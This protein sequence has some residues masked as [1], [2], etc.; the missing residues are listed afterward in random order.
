MPVGQEISKRLMIARLMFNVRWAFRSYLRTPG[1]TITLLL[2]LALGVGATL[3]TFS[4]V[5]ALLLRSLGG[6]VHPHELVR[7]A[8]V[9]DRNELLRVTSMMRDSM[10]EMPAFAGVCAVNTPGGVVTI[11]DRVTFEGLLNVSGD[12]F[13]VLGTRPLLGRLLTAAS[14]AGVRMSWDRRLESTARRSPSSASRNRRFAV[15]R[16][17]FHLQ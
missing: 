16:R 5:D 3:A 10:R 15:Y 6:V 1:L 17:R 14:L 11:G 9:D 12:C 4:L 2:T 7:I 8:A 13:S